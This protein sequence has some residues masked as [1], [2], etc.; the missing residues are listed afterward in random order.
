MTLHYPLD[1]GLPEYHDAAGYERE[2]AWGACDDF[3][4]ALARET[5]GP[6]LDAGCGS[7]LLARAMAKHGLTVTGL[8]VTPEMIDFARQHPD[9]QGVDWVLADVRTMQLGRRYRLILMNGHAFQHLL[10]DED[11]GQFLDRAR[12]H[13]LPDSYLAFET[14]NFTARAWG[15]AGEPE[16][17]GSFENDRGEQVD[18]VLVSE[19]DPES[20]VEKLTFVQ[21][22]QVTGQRDE[23][24]TLLRYLPADHLNELLARH[25]FTVIEQYGDWEKGPLGEDQKEVISICRLASR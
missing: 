5:G 18:E 9:G 8:D 1:Q 3:Y 22:N 23:S 20:G 12:E 19:Y 13:L 25:G 4:L 7:G 24:V 14:R 2:N 10:T 15:Q 6:V 17:W 11:I 21:V 16:P